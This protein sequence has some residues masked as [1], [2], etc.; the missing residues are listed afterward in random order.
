ML[1]KIDP[2]CLSA[3]DFA[4]LIHADKQHPSFVSINPA[5]CVRQLW[6][7]SLLLYRLADRGLMMVEVNEGGDGTKRLNLVRM[8]G[9]QLTLRFEEI[10]R[11]LQHIARELGCVAIETVVYSE[12]L[13]RALRRGGA[14]QESTTMVLE[15]TDG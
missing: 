3:D 13:A 10:S 1:Q 11:D 9:E 12:K 7:G 6:D 2:T 5:E 4:E 14:Y 15:L 8:V